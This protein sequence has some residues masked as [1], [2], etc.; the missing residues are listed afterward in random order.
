MKITQLERT[1]RV[2]RKDKILTYDVICVVVRHTKTFSVQ[3][4]GK[5][6]ALEDAQKYKLEME[7]RL[8]HVRD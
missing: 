3:K 5:E 4:L 2:R 6:K 7:R 1:T 8:K